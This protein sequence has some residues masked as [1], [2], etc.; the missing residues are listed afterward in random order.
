MIYVTSDIHGRFDCLTELLKRAEFS[1]SDWLYIIGDVIDRN[2]KGGVDIL[3]W[4]L[5]HPNVQ[6]LM[7]NHEAFM[8]ANS[9]VF[10]EITD[11]SIEVFN[12]KK[13]SMFNNWRANGGDV[14]VEALRRETTPEERADMLDYLRECPLYE[15]VSVGDR[16]FLLVHAGLGNYRADK[17]ISEY[18]SDELL[19]TR[20]SLN[21]HYSKDF[22]TVIGHTPVHF[23]G[24]QYKGKILKTD[25]WINIDTGA[26]T[27][28]FPCLL[29]LDDMQEFYI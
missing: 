10:D 1:D 26:A 2:C 11:A 24:S 22:T 14:T 27:D 9:W 20:T 7:G 28:L 12:M 5:C 23:Y 3:K 25:T 15:T 13:L 19:W 8:L 6:L 18:T 17:K 4:L 29:R 16:D 21:T